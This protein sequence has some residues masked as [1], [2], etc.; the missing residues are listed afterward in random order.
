[1]VIRNSAFISP[2]S[3]TVVIRALD[4]P[5]TPL[6]RGGEVGPWGPGRPALSGWGRR[7]TGQLVK[8]NYLAADSG[9]ELF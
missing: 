7:G 8:S 9:P 5:A 6:A 4:S 3:I 2:T 1:M